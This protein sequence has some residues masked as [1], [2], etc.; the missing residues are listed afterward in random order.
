LVDAGLSVEVEEAGVAAVGEEEV[1]DEEAGA[2]V[3]EEAVVGEAEA[4]EETEA[5]DVAETVSSFS[6]SFTSRVDASSGISPLLKS[7]RNSRLRFCSA[8]VMCEVM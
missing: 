4:V 3:G 5:D 2:A 6:I 1:V 8:L 7:L